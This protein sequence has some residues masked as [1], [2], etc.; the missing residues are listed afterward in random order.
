MRVH[1]RVQNPPKWPWL[2]GDAAE[3]SMRRS[4]ALRYRLLPMVYSLAH[5]AHDHGTPVVRPL[6]YEFPDDENVAHVEDQFTLGASLLA[7]PVLT[8]NATTRDVVFPRGASWFIFNDTSAAHAGGQSLTLRGLTLQDFP[9][10]VR[11]GSILPL[12]PL[13][14]QWSGAMAATGPLEVQV[15]A[16]TD[17]SFQLVEDDGETTA[18]DCA[19]SG[20]ACETAARRTGLTWTEATSTFEWRCNAG[21]Y[22]GVNA[23]KKLRVVLFRPGTEVPLTSD[24]VVVGTGGKLHLPST[25]STF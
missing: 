15:Y 17:A 8:E 6:M 16:G 22:S 4:L 9:L 10:F 24:I 25:I 2:Y 7:A 23:F 5:H 21:G 14:V 1:S 18:Y 12:A 20:P 11:A 19:A 3:E 13:G